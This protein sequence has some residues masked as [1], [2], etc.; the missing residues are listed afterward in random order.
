MKTKGCPKCKGGGYK[1]RVG[2]HELL[3]NTDELRSMICRGATSDF[4]ED[5]RTRRGGM[6]T[7]FEDLHGKSEI[8][9]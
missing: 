8:R 7:L 3:K 6:R 2:V 4:F 5:C 9:L 1:G